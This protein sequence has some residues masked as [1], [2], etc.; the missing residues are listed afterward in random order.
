[1]RNLKGVILFLFLTISLGS[2]AQIGIGTTSP[3][4]SA[5]LEV[6]SKTKGFL[7]PQV[8]ET[9]MNAIANPASGLTVYCSDCNNGEGC[10]ATYTSGQWQ[11]G[12]LTLNTQC[13]TLFG[14]PNLVAFA[15]G[16]TGSIPSCL[17]AQVQLSCND[18]GSWTSGGATYLWTG[19][20]NFN[21]SGKTPPPFT[22][23]PVDAGIY[24]VTIYN[25]MASGCFQ[26][27]TVSV[28]T[29][30]SSGSGAPS[31]VT[32]NNSFT[33]AVKGSSLNFT[34]NTTGMSNYSQLV[35]TITQTGGTGVTFSSNNTTNLTV[36]FTASNFTQSVS[37][38]AAATASSF[39]VSVYGIDA[40]GNTGSATSSISVT[41]RNQLSI[42]SSTLMVTGHN[43]VS[44]I[45]TVYGASAGGWTTGSL[46]VGTGFSTPPTTFVYGDASQSST[47]VAESPSGVPSGN[48]SSVIGLITWT[49]NYPSTTKY[50]YNFISCNVTFTGCATPVQ[51]TPAAVN[52]VGNYTTDVKGTNIN[53]TVNAADLSNAANLLWTIVPVG[54][55]GVTFNSGG[56]TTLNVANSG[57]NYTQ[58]V[59]V[60]PGAT[61]SSFKVTVAGVDACSVTG[62]ATSSAS[63]AL[64]A[65]LSIASGTLAVA[66]HSAV[67]TIPTVSGALTGAWTSGA[68]TVGSGFTTLPT[69]FAFGSSVTPNTTVYESPVGAPNNNSSTVTGT[70]TWTE[71]YPATTKYTS[72]TLTCA[73]TFAGCTTVSGSPTSVSCSPY[74]TVVKGNSLSFTANLGSM[75]SYNL[76]WTITQTGGT[77][78]TF[79]NGSATTLSVQNLAGNYTQQVDISPTATAT[80]FTVKVQG[81]STCTGTVGTATTSSSISVIGALATVSNVFD[82]YTH[83]ANSTRGGY[84]TLNNMVLNASSGSW[85]LPGGGTTATPTY[86]AS[87]ISPV[88]TVPTHS[89]EGQTISITNP[90][91]PTT[92]IIKED[93]NVTD[94]ASKDKYITTATWT[95]NYPATTK[96]TVNTAS[97]TVRFAGGGCLSMTPSHSGYFAG[98]SPANTSSFN[99]T[100]TYSI[101]RYQNK[102]ITDRNLG[103]TLPPSTVRDSRV[104]VNGWYFVQNNPQ[105]FYHDG[106][107]M[108]PSTWPAWPPAAPVNGLWPSNLDP[109]TILLGNGWRIISKNTF[110][111]LY[112]TTIFNVMSNMYLHMTDC[113]YVQNGVLYNLGNNGAYKCLEATSSGSDY[114]AYFGTYSIGTWQSSASAYTGGAVRCQHK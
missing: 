71:T 100:Y 110:A 28:G 84:D 69:A 113:G 56:L 15:N 29:S 81:Q 96:W 33:A 102:C 58:Q 36:P 26:T 47:T 16:V 55:T 90:S 70:I 67:G 43:T 80:S 52:V 95:E 87:G 54:G 112:F 59:N 12:Q 97:I 85:T 41:L 107:T 104:A 3:N 40:C 2:Y 34:V 11:C 44:P 62:S 65:P 8:T 108:T 7:P 14:D 101:Y 1:M 83:R 66:P 57:A 25:G 63:V 73:L 75:T 77:G 22:F 37:T 74:T 24:T 49:E 92:A 106:T 35:W 27:S 89:P 94:T 111:S 76:L 93:V 78:V 91:S 10:L 30:S 64:R 42:S 19:P 17:G 48:N 23:T 32:V 60:A 31:A 105:G 20:D 98:V 88:I 39:T 109:C 68:L 99:G 38:I 53:F 6:Y 45:P 51:G 61:A 18:N 21:Y 103:A 72:S 13:G 114:Y 50:T 5:Q 82:I 46:S 86:T 79:T 9:Q 4:S